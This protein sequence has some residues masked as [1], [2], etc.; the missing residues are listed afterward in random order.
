MNKIEKIKLAVDV[1]IYYFILN[2]VLYILPT[3]ILPYLFFKN[4]S[5]LRYA[6][7]Y[8]PLI[9]VSICL[10]IISN[11]LKSKVQ[12]DISIDSKPLLHSIVGVL[13]I[14]TGITKSPTF[15]VSLTALIHQNNPLRD[16]MF[17]GVM[18]IIYVVLIGIGAYL[19]FMAI[20][21]DK[22]REKIKVAVDVALYYF[23][24]YTVLNFLVQII[25]S[26][27]NKGY[28]IKFWQIMFSIQYQVFVVAIF[29]LAIISS[30][31]KRKMHVSISIDSKLLLYKIVGF[32]LIIDGVTIIPSHISRINYLYLSASGVQVEKYIL[33]LNILAIAC[34]IIQIGIGV[35]FTLMTIKRDKQIEATH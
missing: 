35:F 25:L 15:V 28:G 22:K 4:T 19:T 24:I 31:I 14:I 1:A 18:I 27:F 12:G 10:V 6:I 2:T 32:L 17:T 9:V 26:L 8:V 29:F 7:A 5:G 23:T 13:F 33:I 11:V 20:K 34:T 21:R 3:L 30:V 16:Y